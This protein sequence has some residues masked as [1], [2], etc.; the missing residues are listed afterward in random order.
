MIRTSSGVVL[1][2]CL[3]VV[4]CGGD[5]ASSDTT[6]TTTDS[7]VV[8]APLPIVEQIDGAVAALEAELGGPQEYFEINATAQL[9]NLFVAL[10]GGTMAQ[11][12]LYFDGQ[13][14]S[15]APAPA[16]GGV[17]LAVDLDFNPSKIFSQLEA[18]LPGV[19]IESF[20][21]HGDGQG[22][23]QYGALLT[24]SQGGGLDVQLGPDGRIIS[25][26]PLN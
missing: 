20:Y 17:L 15:E 16:A 5:D 19:T 7:T 25:S 24:T 6:D 21:I 4:G 12:W 18:E 1:A 3:C 11:P 2:L 23:I 8:A 22:A 10:D 9:V 13:L 14:T 26:E